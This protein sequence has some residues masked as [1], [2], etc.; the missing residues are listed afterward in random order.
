MV[1]ATLVMGIGTEHAD[2]YWEIGDEH[3]LVW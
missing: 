3:E 2:V 1:I